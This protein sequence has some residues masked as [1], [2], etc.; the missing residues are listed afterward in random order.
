MG[1]EVKLLTISIAT[2]QSRS[3]LLSRLLWTLEQQL[4]NNIEV[5][6][7][8]HPT[9]PLGDKSNQ[10]WAEADGEFIM[11]VDDDDLVSSDYVFRVTNELVM[12]AD[13]VSYNALYTLNG[14]F[15]GVYPHD[16][17]RGVNDPSSDIRAL[18]PMM[19]I[20][21]EVART[22]PHGNNMTSD[23]DWSEAVMR[24]WKPDNPVYIDRVLYHYDCWPMHSL[25][26][27]PDGMMRPQRDVGQWPY[28]RER[29]RWIT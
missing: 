8:T 5:L 22:H 17:E 6:V 11:R 10:M 21:T 7:H 18:S 1:G 19:V 12:G 3:S 28:N 23:F 9:L 2:V 15:S 16:I 25:P 29:F 26:N 24:S 27:T 14:R 20:P 13:Y 4:N